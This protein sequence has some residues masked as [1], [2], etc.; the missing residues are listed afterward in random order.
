MPVH[1]TGIELEF[2]IK[3]TR[4]LRFDA[5]CD[6]TREELELASSLDTLK[7]IALEPEEQRSEQFFSCVEKE[8]FVV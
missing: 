7:N 8:F 6:F 5:L 2:K 4:A 1:R 3:T